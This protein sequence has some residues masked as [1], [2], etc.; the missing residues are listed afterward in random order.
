M[1]ALERKKGESLLIADRIRVTV[2]K[3]AR[4]KVVL[5]I[6]APRDVPVLREELTK[7]G[8]K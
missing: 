5:A 8:D 6:S 2:H 3:I 7:G 4:N 1:L